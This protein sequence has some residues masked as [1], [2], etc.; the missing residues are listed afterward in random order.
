MTLIVA[1]IFSSNLLVSDLSNHETFLLI[2]C[3]FFVNAASPRFV[4]M[5][6]DGL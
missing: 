2:Y 4:V 6:Y 3:F 5:V 1:V